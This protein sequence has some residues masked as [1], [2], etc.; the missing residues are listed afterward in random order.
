MVSK[1]FQKCIE[2]NVRTSAQKL[3]LVLISKIM[4][5]YFFGLS[6]FYTL[7][8]NSYNFFV[9]IFGKFY[10]EINWPLHYAGKEVSNQ[11]WDLNCKMLGWKSPFL[12]HKWYLISQVSKTEPENSYFWFTLTGPL[13]CQNSL[14]TH[15]LCW[16]IEN[17]SNCIKIFMKTQ[18]FPVFWKIFIKRD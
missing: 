2:K 5:P 15:N 7:G 12:T 10:S 13:S 14:W 11:T 8:R 9:T 1:F 3:E 4:C 18:L 17:E 6:T 16:Y